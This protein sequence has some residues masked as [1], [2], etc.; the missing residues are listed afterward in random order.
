V[1]GLEGAK[2]AVEKAVGSVVPASWCVPYLSVYCRRIVLY[3]A[4]PCRANY[5]GRELTEDVDA[6][7]SKQNRANERVG[8][9][10]QTNR[11]LC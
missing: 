6:M 1:I 4:V 2:D 5:G 3:C 7:V 10:Q 9:S 11:Y 8:G